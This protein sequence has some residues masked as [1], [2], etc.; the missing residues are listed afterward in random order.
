VE[1]VVTDIR[2]FGVIA[3]VP[4]F[5]FKGAVWL[6]D[7]ET[8]QARVPAGFFGRTPL[9]ESVE[10]G[11]FEWSDSEFTVTP[12]ETGKCVT[13]RRFDRIRVLVTVGEGGYRIGSLKLHLLSM[14]G[15]GR[16]G[17]SGGGGAPLKGVK[18]EVLQGVMEGRSPVLAAAHTMAAGSGGGAAVDEVGER[19]VR[20][21]VYDLLEKF[22]AL[23]LLDPNT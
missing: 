4:R 10:G 8:G 20:K 11:T 2:S 17:G 18:A 9:S 19:T 6:S 16:D 22:K 23:A 5:G 21:P 15:S 14:G 1:A 13:L 3:F 12:A 7:R